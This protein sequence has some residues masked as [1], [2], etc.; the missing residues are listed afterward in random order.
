MHNSPLFSAR[1]FLVSKPL[2][3]LSTLKENNTVILYKILVAVDLRTSIYTD[4]FVLFQC[5]HLDVCR[6]CV[7]FQDLC[8]SL[9]GD[10]PPSCF[11]PSFYVL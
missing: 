2:F 7:N 1:S 10:I 9:L 6:L 11:S 3:W 5:V 8:A 4:F